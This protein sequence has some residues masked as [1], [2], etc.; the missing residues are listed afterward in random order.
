MER[1]VRLVVAALLVL[2]VGSLALP[3]ALALA[4]R[5]TGD[6]ALERQRQLTALAEVAA[7]PAA[8]PSAARYHAVHGE[9]VLVVDG[10]GRPTG[11]AGPI[12][13]D[14]PAVADAVRLALVDDA[15]RPLPRVLPWT[16]EDPVA[17]AT[18]TADGEVVGAAV[19][20]VDT[21]SAA[22]WVGLAWAVIL[23]GAAGLGVL[24]LLL[25]RWVARWAMRPVHALEDSARAMAHGDRG[26]GVL[27]EGPAE[28]RELVTEFNRMADAV[29]RS[30]DDQRRLVADASHQLRNP[31]AALRLRADALGGSVAPSG[32]RTH[33]ALT[34]ELERLESLLDRLLALARAQEAAAARRAGGPGRGEPAGL[35]EVVADRIEAW[36]PLGAAEG[37]GLVA[38]PVEDVAV[39]APGDVAQVLDVLLDNAVRHTG[40]G[41]TVTVSGGDVGG[42]VVLTVRDDGPGVPDG[43]WDRF[44]S[45][46]RRPG[47]VGGSGLGL[48]IADEVLRARGGS[49]VLR[50]GPHGGT[51]AVADLGPLDP[52]P[53]H[54]TAHGT[55][56]REVGR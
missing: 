39:E 35:G 52:R 53:A 21:S 51:E 36:E 8:A 56:S 22:R 6:L 38:G 4:D 46:P 55:A 5:R 42:H 9:P 1:R 50:P 25:T 40:T 23:A 15:S 13:T 49:V 20:R 2:A 37:V 32:A 7:G 26:G 10:Q 16:S 48:A 44:W 14:D 41:T 45:G 12:G 29:Q 24:A 28:L 33:A 11:T 30:L 47:A 43:A 34:R 31:L 3:L 19:T 27:A 17:A 54:G 18:A